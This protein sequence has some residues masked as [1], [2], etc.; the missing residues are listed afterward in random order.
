MKRNGASTER[1]PGRDD[2]RRAVAGAATSLSP[3]RE[4]GLA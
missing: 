3:A 2:G 4:R 1:P